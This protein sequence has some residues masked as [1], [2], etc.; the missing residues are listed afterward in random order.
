MTFCWVGDCLRPVRPGDDQ[1]AVHA[2]AE[3]RA[4]SLHA[5]RR[6]GELDELWPERIEERVAAQR[7]QQ[8]FAKRALLQ[9]LPARQWTGDGSRWGCAVMARVLAELPA[10]AASGG[11]NV[12]MNRAA[13]TAGRLV[14]GGE[15]ETGKAQSTLVA[16]GLAMGLPQFEARSAVRSGFTAGLDHPMVSPSRKRTAE[17]A[18][19]GAAA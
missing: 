11:R 19:W 8:E 3:R 13:W 9:S 6:E 12:A 5:I 10:V 14:A 17:V 4:V 16:A 15:L 18:R 7:A 1:C 2:E